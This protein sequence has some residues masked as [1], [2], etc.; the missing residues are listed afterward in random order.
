MNALVYVDIDW[1]IHKVKLKNALNEKQKKL[2][3]FS[4]SMNMANF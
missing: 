2:H 3:E 4:F 1:G